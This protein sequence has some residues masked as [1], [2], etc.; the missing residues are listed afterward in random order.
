[1]RSKGFY[2]S[3]DFLQSYYVDHFL[4]YLSNDSKVHFGNSSHAIPVAFLKKI[5]VELDISAYYN[6][7]LDLSRFDNILKNRMLQRHIEASFIGKLQ[8]ETIYADLLDVYNIEVPLNI[9]VEYRRLFIDISLVR[10]LEDWFCYMRTLPKDEQI[11]RNQIITQPS[12][13]VR[14][15]LGCK[16]Y[17]DPLVA[18]QQISTDSYWL[19]KESLVDQSIQ[20]RENTRR[21]AELAFKATDRVHKINKDIKPLNKAKS[22][23]QLLLTFGEAD[24][25][26]VDDLRMIDANENN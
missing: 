15:K 24:S 19:Y 4:V 16:V 23:N 12:E 6:P 10:N 17:I 25:T 3:E 13:Y 1:M 26:T 22:F 2:V 9:L 8:P 5:T 20:G 11:F 7:K 14:W 18:M 21:L